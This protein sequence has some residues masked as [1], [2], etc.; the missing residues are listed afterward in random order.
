MS[1]KNFGGTMIYIYHCHCG[2]ILTIE[3]DLKVANTYMC[4]KCKETMVQSG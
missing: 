2:H 3:T 4:R 1:T